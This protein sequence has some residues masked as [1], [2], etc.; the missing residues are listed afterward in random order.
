MIKKNKLYKIF[1]KNC[2][3][4]GRFQKKKKKLVEFSTKRGL[5]DSIPKINA[6]HLPPRVDFLYE[7]HRVCKLTI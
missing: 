3:N 4:K 5:Y 2:L 6:D 1:V 7:H